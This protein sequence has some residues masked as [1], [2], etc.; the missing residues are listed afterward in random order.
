[1]KCTTK[2]FRNNSVTVIVSYKVFISIS[3]VFSITHTKDP[4]AFHGLFQYLEDKTIIADKAGL[5]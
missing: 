1:M 2:A 3:V 4:S 5:I